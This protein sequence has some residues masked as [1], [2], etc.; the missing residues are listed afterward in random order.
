MANPG[1]TPSYHPDLS[2][3][4]LYPTNHLYN[5]F[6]Q[7]STHSPNSTR[8]STRRCV[9]TTRLSF[10]YAHQLIHASTVIVCCSC[11]CVQLLRLFTP[12]LLTQVLVAIFTPMRF[13]LF[14]T[15]TVYPDFRRPEKLIH[16]IGTVTPD[17]HCSEHYH[18]TSK[19]CYIFLNY[20]FN[21]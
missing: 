9:S 5:T 7:H 17:R 2:P 12:A 13:C 11:S 18:I 21:E 4:P 1:F 16:I 3:Y 20:F 19:E 10:S 15:R 14:L 6:L 8:Y